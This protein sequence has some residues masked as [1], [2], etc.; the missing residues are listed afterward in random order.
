MNW[1]DRGA[2]MMSGSSLAMRGE[3]VRVRVSSEESV[4]GGCQ[5]CT[6][7]V[8]RDVSASRRRKQ[9]QKV[10]REDGKVPGLLKLSTVPT[11][12]VVRTSVGSSLDLLS[13]DGDGWCHSCV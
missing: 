11:Y 1:T 9:E 5:R 2:A 10:R 12:I 13:M 3:K 7:W 8:S 4:V 6:E